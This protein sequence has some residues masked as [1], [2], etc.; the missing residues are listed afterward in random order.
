MTKSR[1]A[2]LHG[3]VVLRGQPRRPRGSVRAGQTLPGADALDGPL[4]GRLLVLLSRLHRVDGASD[5]HGGG[6]AEEP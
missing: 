5:A 2:A 4:P 3:P 1:A 6:E